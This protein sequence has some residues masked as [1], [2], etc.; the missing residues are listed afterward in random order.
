MIYWEQIGLTKREYEVLILITE[1]YCT[2]EIAS[3]LEISFYTVKDYRKSLLQK[4]S[5]KNCAELCYKASK[6]DLV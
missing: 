6:L 2:K 3:M 4:I 1:G 5:A